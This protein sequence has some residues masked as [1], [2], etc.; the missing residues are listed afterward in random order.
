MT[1]HGLGAVELVLHEVRVQP[2]V[3]CPGALRDGVGPVAVERASPELRRA[4]D[5][6]N[7]LP[8]EAVLRSDLPALE[9][10]VAGD[11]VA[12]QRMPPVEDHWE[13]AVNLAQA[14]LLLAYELRLAFLAR[15]G[16]ASASQEDARASAGEVE[17][18]LEDGTVVAF[19]AHA[20][21]R[22]D[23]RIIAEHYLSHCL[24]HD[25]AAFENHRERRG[26]YFASLVRLAIRDARQTLKEFQ[27]VHIRERHRRLPFRHLQQIQKEEAR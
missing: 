7:A 4:Q 15:E 17:Q 1:E 9:R 10:L 27:Q 2:R 25:Y 26:S 14:V 5:R 22:L 6:T 8:R 18:A 3:A 13:T 16:E 12:A 23:E 20:T 24:S 21:V 19:C 11:E